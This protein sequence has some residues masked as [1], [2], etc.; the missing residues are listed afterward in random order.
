MTV[1]VQERPEFAS[2]AEFWPFY[3]GAHKSPLCRAVHYLGA[4]GGLTLPIL[5]IAT[6]PWWLLT[7]APVFGYGCAWIGH[8]G[9]EGNHPATFEYPL[10]SFLA[11]FKMFWYGVTGRM[12]KEVQRYYGDD[13]SC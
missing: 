10:Y 5:A 6:G 2:F 4:V 7:L 8:F 13:R 12:P 3:V 11:E 9:C 1:S